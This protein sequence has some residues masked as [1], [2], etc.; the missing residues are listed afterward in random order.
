MLT[1]RAAVCGCARSSA[2]V[3]KS[4]FVATIALPG[5]ALPALAQ[6]SSLDAFGSLIGGLLP[7]VALTF[8]GNGPDGRSGAGIGMNGV[9]QGLPVGQV[10]TKPSK[11]QAQSSIA[12][13]T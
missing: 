13:R 8:I 2:R 6:S 11:L 4:F 9:H 10:A 5:F 7:S 12:Q 1:V 3:L